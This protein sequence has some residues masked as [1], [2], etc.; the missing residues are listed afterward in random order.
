MISEGFMQLYFWG[1]LVWFTGLFVVL[2]IPAT[3]E[4]R[5]LLSGKKD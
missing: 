4:L 1:C 3:K 2:A 5:K